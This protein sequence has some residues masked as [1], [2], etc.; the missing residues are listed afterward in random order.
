MGTQG[1]WRTTVHLDGAGGRWRQPADRGRQACRRTRLRLL[2]DA[3][4]GRA[5]V[6]RHHEPG[7]LDDG[8][9][10]EPQG[11]DE[12]APLRLRDGAVLLVPARRR[13]D[14]RARRR[15]LG[16]P[17]HRGAAQARRAGGRPTWAFVVLGLSFVFEGARS[18]RHWCSYRRD[19]ARGLGHGPPPAPRPTPPCARWCGRTA[20]RWSA[21][22][23]R[24]GARPRRVNGGRTWD[25]VASLAIAAL[26]V[27]VAYGLGRQNQ[28]YLIGKAAL[29][30]AAGG[31]QPRRSATPPASTRFSSCSRCA[32]RPTRCWWR[33][34][35]T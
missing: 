11:A 22:C 29:A 5:L 17:G 33:R 25:G 21:C 20:P 8:A 7:V 14:L 18:S 16:V 35:S 32:S 10:A 27:G 9:A 3:V 6:R 2:G 15:L 31:D 1:A 13:R 4:R 12:R 34:A 24:Q 30:G 19:A 28:Q 23:W 26:L